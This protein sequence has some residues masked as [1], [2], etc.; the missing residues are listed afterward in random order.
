MALQRHPGGLARLDR[1]LT[2]APARGG[3]AARRQRLMSQLLIKSEAM[4]SRARELA[5]HYRLEVTAIRGQANGAIV[6]AMIVLAALGAGLNAALARGLNRSLRELNQ[7][8][9]RIGGGDLRHEIRVTAA[10]EL[11]QLAVAF[12]GMSA[13][14]RESYASLDDLRR[15]IDQRER[16]ERAAQQYAAELETA[17]R[18]L[19]GFSY[20]VSHDLRAPLRAIDGFSRILLE[21]YRE[22]LDDEGR[23]LLD[24]VR[25]STQKMAQLIDDILEFSRMGRRE[26]VAAELDMEAVARSV[27]QELEPSWAGRDLRVELARLPPAR[28]DGPLLHQVWAN[29]LGNAVKFTRPKAGAA[30]ELGGRVEARENVY[31]VKDNGVGFDMRYADKLFGVFQRL[32]GPQEFEGTGIGLAIVKRIVARHGG[33]VWAEGKVNE[34]ATFYFALPA[35]GTT[36]E[37]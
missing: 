20:S 2:A 6:A 37:H 26:L 32:H 5:E 34:G 4:R 35:A 25:A 22:R 1:Q 7:G 11:G 27:L 36:A 21:D 9:A 30:V 8:V 13:R 3:D 18:E 17:N 16:A 31:Y 15:E 10:D 28:G 19:E 23:R 24:V 33:R 14:L 12:N 29:L